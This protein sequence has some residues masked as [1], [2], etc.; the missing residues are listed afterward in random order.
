MLLAGAL[1]VALVAVAAMACGDDDDDDVASGGVSEEQF[2]K[3]AVLAALTA[4]RAEGPHEID[5]AAQKA[6]EIEAGWGGAVDRMHQVAV[7]IEWP[8]DMK[9]HA[10]M[11][12]AALVKCDQDLKDE[13]LAAFKGDFMEAHA[14]W[15]ELDG[16]GYAFISGV[17]HDEGDHAVATSSPG[18]SDETE[19]PTATH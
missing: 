14:H 15:H 3:T 19:A 17:E 9:E 18:S 6:G 12:I 7:S 8:G 13:D 11:L 10:D 5:Q 1:V 2:Q 4:L 16:V